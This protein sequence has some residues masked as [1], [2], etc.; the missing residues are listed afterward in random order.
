MGKE[1]PDAIDM[2]VDKSRVFIDAK[3]RGAIVIHKTASNHE[4]ETAQNTA[5][6]FATT[7]EK[8][9]SHFVI[10]RDGAVVQC[11]SLNDGAAANCCRVGDYNLYWDQFDEDNLNLVTISIE[12]VDESEWNTQDPTQEQL[13]AS[14]KLCLWLRDNY[15]MQAEDILQHADIDPVNRQFCAGNFP[16]DALRSHVATK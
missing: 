3:P 12:H 16:L 1:Y 9:S 8:T 14:F 2:F 7:P 6:Y 5:T 13:D 15:D 11:V 4:G 10:G